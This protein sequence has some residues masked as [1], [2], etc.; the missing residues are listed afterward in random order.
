MSRTQ[1]LVATAALFAGALAFP[2]LQADVD[3]LKERIDLLERRVASLERHSETAPNGDR[4]VQRSPQEAR[5]AQLAA[6]EKQLGFEAET[7]DA[8]LVRRAWRA[9]VTQASIQGFQFALQVAGNDGLLRVSEKPELGSLESLRANGAR[10][11]APALATDNVNDAYHAIEVGVR[12]SLVEWAKR[13]AADPE[14]KADELVMRWR[15][16]GLS[17]VREKLEQ[18]MQLRAAF[19]QAA[20]E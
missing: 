4:R 18:G 1:L 13:R 6:L 7:I 9:K 17:I 11:A 16:A 19:E 12:E 5:I 2:D 15:S 14:K 20:E 8:D 10:I 3:G